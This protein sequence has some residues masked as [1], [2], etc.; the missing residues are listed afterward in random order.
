PNATIADQ[1]GQY[2]TVYSDLDGEFCDTAS[3]GY[4]IVFDSSNN[5]FGV[6]LQN[7]FGTSTTECKTYW[8]NS[9]TAYEG[10]WTHISVVFNDG[11][12]KMITDGG[13][14]VN[15]WSSVP[16]TI[17][18][19]QRP[20]LGGEDKASN[21]QHDEPFIGWIDEFR[22]WNATLSEH[23]MHGEFNRLIEEG[24][25]LVAVFGFESLEEGYTVDRL[26]H[27]S[28]AFVREGALH[29]SSAPL[30]DPVGAGHYYSF[31]GKSDEIQTLTRVTTGVDY[32]VEAW[33]RT[34]DTDSL[35]FIASEDR[36]GGTRWELKMDHGYVGA[37][38]NNIGQAGASSS[39]ADLF[40]A[41]GLWHHVAFTKNRNSLYVFVDG[42]LEASR[43]AGGVGSTDG[44]A[45]VTV[46]GSYAA[47]GA[48]VQYAGDM[49]EFRVWDHALSPEDVARRMT[50]T[51][52]GDE[53]G[54]LLYY[55]FD[56]AAGK[57]VKDDSFDTR[58]QTTVY[59]ETTWSRLG[60]G[61]ADGAPVY[62]IDAPSQA[63]VI[64]GIGLISEPILDVRLLGAF[65][66]QANVMPFTDQT[67]SEPTVF[68]T[69]DA[70]DGGFAVGVSLDSNGDG[71][72]DLA[73]GDVL[74]RIDSDLVNADA[75][76]SVAVVFD[77]TTLHVYTNGTYVDS[78]RPLNRNDPGGLGV[79]RVGTHIESGNASRTFSGAIDAIHLWSVALEAQ[80]IGDTW[81][82]VPPSSH[83]DLLSSWTFDGTRMQA[84][85]FVG[86]RFSYDFEDGL[87]GWE[88]AY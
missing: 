3:E 12:L 84:N 2:A 4:A 78:W 10:T 49:D 45:R 48:E 43:Y 9:N 46:G 14:I 61:Y 65:T 5:R 52:R 57:E 60:R 67:S 68:S 16:L 20:I 55:T 21:P 81:D 1:V 69:V 29:V 7:G 35:T 63:A 66:L 64:D 44:S 18:D 85:P 73:W 39:D 19:R 77:E 47:Y 56:G 79:V 74:H 23:Q 82:L 70:E 31:N 36:N 51:V 86:E 88:L 50:T 33:V 71:G 41:D 58:R 30:R 54:L 26:D 15:S 13:S 59:G 42:V 53:S 32:S 8:M 37:W 80:T 87:Q 24:D 40:V 22:W 72:V 62:G 83:P 38:E 11:D 28:P 27:L 6:E 75:W 25:D 34:T 76:V 17:N